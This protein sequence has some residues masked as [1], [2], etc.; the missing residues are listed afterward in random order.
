MGEIDAKVVESARVRALALLGR[1]EEAIELGKQVRA[2]FVQIGGE[3]WTQVKALD[4]IIS[5]VKRGLSAGNVILQHNF[6]K[7][8]FNECNPL[9][10]PHCRRI[11]ESGI[12]HSDEHFPLYGIFLLPDAKERKCT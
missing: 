2:F 1:E 4:R 8:G 10:N 9:D 3:E 6:C 11:I 5:K 12:L 7:F